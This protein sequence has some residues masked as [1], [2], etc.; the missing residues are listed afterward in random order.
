MT[1]HLSILRFPFENKD[2]DAEIKKL[3]NLSLD[4]GEEK[5]HSKEFQYPPNILASIEVAMAGLPYLYTDM[6]HQ[7]PRVKWDE[8]DA[9]VES[10]PGSSN[11]RLPTFYVERNPHDA[12]LPCMNHV[13]YLF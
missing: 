1:N 13:P 9:S 6:P 7:I 8:A 2:V 11:D 4:E 10:S 5:S 12:G 3:R